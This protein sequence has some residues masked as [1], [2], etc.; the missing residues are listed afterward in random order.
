MNH[1]PESNRDRL[2]H[3]LDASLAHYNRAAEPRAGLEDRILANLRSQPVAEPSR[4]FRWQWLTSGAIAVAAVVLIAVMLMPKAQRQQPPP[5][6]A[7]K[8]DV[9][10]AV[11]TNPMSPATQ[12]MPASPRR[13]LV[14]HRPLATRETS[15]STHQV[16]VAAA[17]PH[18]D[19]FPAP[20][21]LSSQEQMLLS[22]VRRTPREV[23]VAVSEE[24]QLHEQEWMQG[25]QALQPAQRSEQKSENLK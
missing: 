12:T 15:E 3:I 8:T 7:T 23:L 14:R 25:D 1:E 22:Y 18:L 21:P 6:T 19:V 11:E 16:T 10:R 17:V 13:L 5:L 4:W 9:P 2:D 24:Q 20:T